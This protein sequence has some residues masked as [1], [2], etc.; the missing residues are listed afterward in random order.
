MHRDVEQGLGILEAP[1]HV[2]RG[3]VR[4]PWLSTLSNLG[5]ASAHWAWP[6][7]IASAVLLCLMWR[8]APGATRA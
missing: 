6:I 4:L 3:G 7:L 1:L 5:Y 2:A 8:S